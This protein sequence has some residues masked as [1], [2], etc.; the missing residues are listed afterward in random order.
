L[1]AFCIAWLNP[2]SATPSGQI[3]PLGC[4]AEYQK[5]GVARAVLTEALRRLANCGAR[6]VFVETDHFRGPALALYEPMGFRIMREIRV[7]R[8]ESGS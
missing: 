6:Q 3:E 5:R 2:H 4:R 7:Y 8:K 1:A